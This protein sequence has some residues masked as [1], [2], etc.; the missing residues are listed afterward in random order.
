M[1][2]ITEPKTSDP[3]ALAFRA[4]WAV[5]PPPIAATPSSQSIGVSAAGS[6]LAV[7]INGSTTTRPAPTVKSLDIAAA[8]TDTTALKVDTNAGAIAAPI[9]YDGRP[10]ATSTVRAAAR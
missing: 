2:A 5:A 3:I 8:A 7:T 4:P 6:D 10:P 9:T 1:A